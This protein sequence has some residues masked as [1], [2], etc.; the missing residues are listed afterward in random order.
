MYLFCF[1]S[2]LRLRFLACALVWPLPELVRLAVFS[3]SSFIFWVVKFSQSSSLSVYCCLFIRPVHSVGSVS[4]YT[5][6]SK[7][8]QFLWIFLHYFITCSGFFPHCWRASI[9]KWR[10]TWWVWNGIIISCLSLPV[11][12]SRCFNDVTCQPLHL[13]LPWRLICSN[14]TS[15]S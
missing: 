11:T 15:T 12:I 7:R 10:V 1:I 14:P 3:L 8:F 9:I 4:L 13:K 2:S 6:G 5:L